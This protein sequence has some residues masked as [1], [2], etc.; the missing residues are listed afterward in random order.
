MQIS[1]NWSNEIILNFINDI[2]RYPELWDAET[3]DYRS[4]KKRKER[5]HE[6]AVKYAVTTGDAQK[7]FKSLRT[8]A[9]NEEK[10]TLSKGEDGKRVK[11]SWFA[12][13]A[14]SFIRSQDNQE[15]SSHNQLGLE[16]SREN[17]NSSIKSPMKKKPRNKEPDLLIGEADQV[18]DEI[19]SRMNDDY[20]SFGEHIAQK[21][22]T[23]SSKIR[24]E[25]Q[26]EI[27]Q[28]IYEADMRML[29]LNSS[30]SN[31]LMN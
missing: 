4:K 31:V 14:M 17:N 12:Y 16:S 25:V 21:L 1:L 26:F 24:A 5:W 20:T 10:K 18:D 13:D 6:I 27:S 22:A 8:Y 3:P 29:G 30:D 11:S 19:A 7:K 15:I 28:V 2:S 23:Y 9:K